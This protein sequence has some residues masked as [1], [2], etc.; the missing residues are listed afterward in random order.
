MWLAGR[1]HESMCWR[2]MEAV[3]DS[4]YLRGR[5]TLLNVSVVGGEIC[6]L[7]AEIEGRRDSRRRQCFDEHCVS[8]WRR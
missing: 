7:V 5:V 6:N 4:G 2:L 8:G 1:A 3:S